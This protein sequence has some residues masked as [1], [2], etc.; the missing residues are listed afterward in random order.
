MMMNP[1]HVNPRF[2]Q[3]PRRQQGVVLY[4]ALVVMV[5]MMLA[6]GAMLR[7]VG[8]GVGVTG[9]LAFK[10]NATLAGDLGTQ[11][12]IAWILSQPA[13]SM[14]QN[15]PASGYFATWDPSFKPS[16][17]DWSSAKLVPLAAGVPDTGNTVRYV[18]HRLCSASGIPQ[19]SAV[20]ECSVSGNVT[21]NSVDGNSSGVQSGAVSPP[22]YRVTTRVDGPRGTL[23]FIQVVVE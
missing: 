9:N 20:Q 6:G 16:A 13:L 18:I 11:A 8:T 23:S 1:V 15:I 2:V 4:V 22:L 14:E 5:V 3:W 21:A 10:Q 7:S 12:A 17:F 19:S